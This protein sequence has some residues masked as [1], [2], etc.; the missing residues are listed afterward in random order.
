MA[1][2]FGR[3]I[4]ACDTQVCD[5]AKIC[6]SADAALDSCISGNMVEVFRVTVGPTMSFI[7]QPWQL[8]L[9]ILAGLSSPPLAGIECPLTADEG[10][11]DQTYPV[12]KCRASTV[13]ADALRWLKSITQRRGAQI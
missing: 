4:R 10:F 7:L 12:R 1:R 6:L 2:R 13:V 5:M 9:M 3:I 11:D 8:L